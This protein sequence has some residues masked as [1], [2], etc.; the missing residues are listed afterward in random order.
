MKT[1]LTICLLVAAVL[2]SGCRPSPKTLAEKYMAL[3]CADDQLYKAIE[4]AET[5][6]ERAR[7]QAKK[8]RVYE[9]MDKISA[10][11]LETYHGDEEAMK[12]IQEVSENYR[13][14]EN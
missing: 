11:I 12:M 1:I 8:R 10:Q 14:K 3:V 7:L 4:D 2:L 5:D 13:C 6:K 9:Q